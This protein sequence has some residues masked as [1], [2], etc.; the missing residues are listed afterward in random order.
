MALSFY[1]NNLLLCE[2]SFPEELGGEGLCHT[3]GND[4]WGD[5]SSIQKWKSREVRDPLFI[6]SLGGGGRESEKCLYQN[7]TPQ[8]NYIWKYY[9]PP[10]PNPF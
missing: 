8:N 6:K 1:L 7:F 5:M 4:G 9:P 3:Y 2:W 10:Y